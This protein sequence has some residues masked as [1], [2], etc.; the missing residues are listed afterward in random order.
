MPFQRL[1]TLCEFTGQR[2]G[3]P[4]LLRGGQFDPLTLSLCLDEMENAI[5]IFVPKIFGVK[6]TLE[7]RNEL[8]GHFE[9][10]TREPARMR[11]RQV[12]RGKYFLRVMQCDEREVVAIDSKCTDIGFFAHHPT[13]N[14]FLVLCA[15]RFGECKVGLPIA[16]R[17][18][19]IWAVVP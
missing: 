15:K 18:E 12:A 4:L 3:R 9:F 11:R 13:R 16:V 14:A 10:L 19:E 1:Q 17:A 2:C 6:F 8:L 7:R 5:A